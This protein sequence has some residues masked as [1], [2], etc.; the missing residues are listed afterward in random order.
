MRPE[1]LKFKA[2]GREQV[3]GEGKGFL[4]RRSV[5]PPPPAMEPGG[6]HSP[7]RKCILDALRAQKISLVA[8]DVA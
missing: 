6:A 5:P 1:G 8:A 3:L 2:E 7:G 4:R